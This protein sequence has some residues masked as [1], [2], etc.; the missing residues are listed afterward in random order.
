MEHSSNDVVQVVIRTMSIVETLA[1]SKGSLGITQIAKET[2]LSKATVSRLL[3]TLMVSGYVQRESRT[4]E[5]KLGLKFL[6]ISSSIIERQDIRDIAR[7]YLNRLSNATK[8]IVHLAI[9]DRDEIVYIDKVEGGEHAVRIFSVVGKRSPMH[10]TGLGKAF[11]STLT[12]AE[13]EEVVV[14][15]GLKKYTANTITSLDH[16]K[17]ELAKIRAKGCSYDEAEHEI[18]IWCVAAP[19]L[20]N[21]GKAIAA[22]SVTV[23]EIYM[24][25]ERKLEFSEKMIGVSNEISRQLGYMKR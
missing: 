21:N 19:I 10:C 9:M 1:K 6:E 15:K 24:S 18:G 11:L 25:E 3:N 17:K 23:P 16:L 13:V 2:E 7:P 20:D 5:Y 22:I 8:E 4:R 12:D 14:R